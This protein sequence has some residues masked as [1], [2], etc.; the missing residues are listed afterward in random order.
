MIYLVT[1]IF[2]VLASI[3]AWIYKLV[4]EN[5]SLKESKVELIMMQNL[6]EWEDKIAA[7]SAK[8]KE[9]EVDYD[10]AKKQF[11]TNNPE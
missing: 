2:A 10:T 9:D 11:N 7:S 4:L 1:T 5:K 6:K 3:A 8:I